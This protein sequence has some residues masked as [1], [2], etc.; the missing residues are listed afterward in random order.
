MATNY[1]TS[2]SATQ[3]VWTT[4]TI[5]V[6]L[7]HAV[8]TLTA[9][10][11]TQPKSVNVVSTSFPAV[12]VFASDPWYAAA[13]ANIRNLAIS[14]PQPTCT[15]VDSVV[16]FSSILAV[17]WFRPCVSGNVQVMVVGGGAVGL[18]SNRA[19]PG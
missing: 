9:L 7:I 1:F 4:I 10:G 16:T 8:V 11:T 19:E 3:S 13:A 5:V 2:A 15:N 14:A 18:V 12:N 17:G 6:D